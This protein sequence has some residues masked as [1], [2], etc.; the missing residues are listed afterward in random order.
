MELD[1]TARRNLELTTSLRTGEKRGSLLWVLDHTKTA[2]GARL[3]KQWIE[4]PLRSVPQI[5]SRQNAV[6]ELV[7]QDQLRDDLAAAMAKIYDMERIIGRIV[8]GS[9]NCRDLRALH[10]VCTQLPMLR[11]ALRP[12]AAPM[13]QRLL[14]E[15]D[16]LSDIGEL[17]DR[18]IVDEPPFTVREG[19]M[20][21]PGFDPSQR[22][23]AWR[24]GAH[25]HP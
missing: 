7:K 23:R 16:D 14:K 13:L 22:D 3:L 18:S 11:E 15:M 20:I 2:M 8:Y 1:Y 25:R 19:G 9:A 6:A 4:R 21:R 17:I 5:Q 24:A 12:T 10:Q